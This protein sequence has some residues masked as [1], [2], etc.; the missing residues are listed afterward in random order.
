SV[1]I[2]DQFRHAFYREM[3]D[4]LVAI[5]RKDLAE[6]IQEKSAEFQKVLAW[7]EEEDW[8][9]AVKRFDRKF[10]G[11]GLYRSWKTVRPRLLQLSR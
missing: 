4:P 6:V 8:K 7:K 9:G 3:I 2:V 1:T 10:L 5:G 11:A